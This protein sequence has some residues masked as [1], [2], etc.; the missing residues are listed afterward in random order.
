MWVRFICKKQSSS[1]GDKRWIEEPRTL[2]HYILCSSKVGVW[3][4]HIYSYLIWIIQS[5]HYLREESLFFLHCSKDWK[6]YTFYKILISVQRVVEDPEIFIRM[7]PPVML[8]WF[9]KLSTNFFPQRK[10]LGPLWSFQN[11]NCM[12]NEKNK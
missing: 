2:H 10:G 11:V 3:K 8:K 5:W 7:P 6:S 12:K 4:S 9:P 1:S